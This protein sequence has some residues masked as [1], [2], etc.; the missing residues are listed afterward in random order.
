MERKQYIKPT[1][2]QLDFSTDEEV[3]SFTSCKTSNDRTGSNLGVTCDNI[4]ELGAPCNAS[5]NS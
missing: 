3:V 4:P 5:G 1:V 2:M